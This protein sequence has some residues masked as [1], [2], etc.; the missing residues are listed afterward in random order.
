MWNVYY[1]SGT[2]LNELFHLHITTMTLWIDHN[3][4]PHFLDKETV[5]VH[6]IYCSARIQTPDICFSTCFTNHT[7][8]ILWVSFGALKEMYYGASLVAQR[9]SSHVPLQR[10][11]V[12]QFGSP[13]QTYAPLVKPC[14]SRYPTYKKKK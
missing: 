14:Y 5:Q 1:M 6:S 13:V 3:C 8:L 4:Y 2:V 11:G 7:L 12:C 9:L 10:L